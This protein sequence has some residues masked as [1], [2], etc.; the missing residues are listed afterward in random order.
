MR[1][2][3]SDRLLGPPRTWAGRVAFVLAV[4]A[5]AA[6]A[7]FF[8]V[9]FFVAAAIFAAIF[10]ARWWWLSRK[11]RRAQT[12]GAIEG[13]YVVVKN[14]VEESGAARQSGPARV[15]PRDGDAQ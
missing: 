13:E 4:I 9:I 12:G 2:L 7:F 15:L 8:L 10:I 11:A 14:G 1:T 3:K 5:L 6:L